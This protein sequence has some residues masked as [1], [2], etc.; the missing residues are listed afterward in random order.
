MAETTMSDEAIDI[1]TVDEADDPESR[2]VLF[3]AYRDDELGEEKRRAVEVRL[4]EDDA[5]RGAYDEYLNF[6]AELD[7]IPSR[8]APAGF[9]AAVCDRLRR[10]SGGRFFGRPSGLDRAR[11]TYELAAVAMLAVMT[12]AYLA[13]GISPDRGL[14][15]AEEPALE[16]PDHATT[17]A[18]DQIGE[19]GR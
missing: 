3:G 2:D 15:T 18:V 17:R 1:P 16:V 19:Q 9:D 6:V 12:S 8:E 5:F 14:E 10:R 4:E 13:V 11:R 7:E